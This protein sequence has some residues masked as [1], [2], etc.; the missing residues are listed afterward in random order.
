MKVKCIKDTIGFKKWEV[1]ETENG[2]LISA[3]MDLHFWKKYTEYFQEQEEEEKV[4]PRWKVGDY[5]VQG[6]NWLQPPDYIKIT[7]V[8]MDSY[9]CFHY[10]DE[11]EEEFRNP[12]QEELKL[13]FR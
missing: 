1:Y 12:T 7:K 11:E 10:N 6:Y 13:Y 8:W 9:W 5:V 4:L 2:C 3:D